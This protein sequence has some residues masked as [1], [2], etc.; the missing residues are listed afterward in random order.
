MFVLRSAAASNS[1]MRS[2]TSSAGP[3]TSIGL[4]PRPQAGV[5]LHHCDRKAVLPK[6]IRQRRPG[7]A[8]A[9][10]QNFRHRI[11]AC[12][13]ASVKMSSSI[14]GV[15]LPVNIFCWLGW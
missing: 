10:H 6:P 1:P 15:N 14:V 7:H 8:S 5:A 3:R 9:G 4:T 2:S 12:F 11:P 13:L